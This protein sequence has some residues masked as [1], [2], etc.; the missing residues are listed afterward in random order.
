MVWSTLGV[1]IAASGGGGRPGTPGEPT[2]PSAMGA[3]DRGLHRR[4]GAGHAHCVRAGAVVA[5]VLHGRP[6]AAHAGVFAAGDG[7]HR[8]LRAAGDSV[9][10]AGRPAD[11]GQRHVVAAHRAAAAHVRPAARR[12]GADHHHGHGLLLGR[13]GLQAGRHRGGGRHHHAGRAQDQTG[14]ERNR[15]PAGLHRGDG[16]DHSALH[17]HDHHGLRG[18]HL[19]CRAVHGRAGAGGGAGAVAGRGHDLR[20]HAHQ[21]RRSLR[22][23]H[24]DVPPAGRRDWWRW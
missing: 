9:L 16:R 5:G 7:R 6:V 15:R 10:R 3:A 20:G 4:H 12:A 22:R 1:G 14:P 2:T 8:P 24:A 21:P 11:G 18:Q 17:Q 19:D 23:A 13:V